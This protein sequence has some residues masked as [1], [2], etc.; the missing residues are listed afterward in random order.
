MNNPDDFPKLD[1]TECEKIADMWGKRYPFIKK[2]LLY[3]GLNRLFNYVLVAEMESDDNANYLKLNRDWMRNNNWDNGGFQTPILGKGDHSYGY[4][5]ERKS[6][7]FSDHWQA[8]IKRSEGD[9]RYA[10]FARACILSEFVWI[11]YDA[12]AHEEDAANTVKFVQQTKLRPDQQVKINCQ[13]IAKKTWEQ[14]LLLDIVHMI[15]LPEIKKI[16][17][18]FYKGKTVHNWLKVVAPDRARKGGRRDPATRAKQEEI[19][20]KLSIEV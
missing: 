20:K 11:L 17:G 16:V 15:N 12:Q 13:E 8:I 1:L 5:E 2:I 6:D 19:C 18:R 4:K 14:Y 10:E 7:V 3:A 9:I